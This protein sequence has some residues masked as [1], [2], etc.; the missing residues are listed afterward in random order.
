MAWQ[1]QGAVARPAGLHEQ[2]EVWG[3]GGLETEQGWPR[4]PCQPCLSSGFYSGVMG[5]PR[6]HLGGQCF[7]ILHWTAGCAGG[8]VEAKGPWGSVQRSWREGGGCTER[9]TQIT[10]VSRGNA[11]GLWRHSGPGASRVT[12]SM[13]PGLRGLGSTQRRRTQLGPSTWQ[14]RRPGLAGTPQEVPCGGRAALHLC[15]W[16]VCA[17]AEEIQVAS[18]EKSQWRGGRDLARLGSRP[19]SGVH[20]RGPTSP[21]LTE[22]TANL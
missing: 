9:S 3:E 14:G 8:R 19:K 21:T 16:R 15:S 20:Q 10:H 6:R 18:Q 5:N 4:G 1:V 17:E 13:Q 11:E 7:S 2:M 22:H 12:A